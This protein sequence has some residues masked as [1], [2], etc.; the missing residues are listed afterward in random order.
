MGVNLKP[1]FESEFVEPSHFKGKI[2]AVDALNW[3]FQFISTIRQRDGTLLMDSKGR[4][5]S[6]LSG[7]FYRNASLIKNGIKPVYVFDG[8]PPEFKKS[9]QEK[10]REE[11][12]KYLKEY[13]EALKK[14]D[15]ERAFSLSTRT[16]FVDEEVLNTSKE[17]L[18]LM[19]IPVVQ[20]PSEG[21]AQCSYMNREGVVDYVASQDYDSILFGTK[22]LVRNLNITGKRKLPRSKEYVVVLPEVIDVEANL[23]RLGIDRDKL[24]L[25]GMLVGNDYTEG[26]KGVGP[27]T[28]LKIVKDMK[29]NEII[30]KYNLNE[31]II[32]WF[33]HPKVKDVKIEFKKANIEKLREFLLDYEFSEERIQKTLSEIE[34]AQGSRQSSL[35]SYF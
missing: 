2:I 5:T 19:G 30:K 10:R 35:S 23:N 8:E 17:I 25:I 34:K 1:L 16:A 7:L 31:E 13:K 22:M 9:T 4:V 26:V 18:N 28:A 11:K 6:H 14:G 33:K 21:E 15:I 29:E 27:K 3:I 20:A 32:D 12:E 24:V